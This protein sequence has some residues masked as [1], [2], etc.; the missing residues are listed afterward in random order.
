[1]ESG[2]KT[3]CYTAKHHKMIQVYLASTWIPHSQNSLRALDL[4]CMSERHE[5]V[6]NMVGVNFSL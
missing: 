1:M 5:F 6:V 2:L 3:K 4:V